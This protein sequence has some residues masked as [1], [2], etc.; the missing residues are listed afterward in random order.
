MTTLFCTPAQ[1]FRTLAMTAVLALTAFAMLVWGILALATAHDELVS[2]LLVIA[3]GGLLFCL[4]TAVF[5]LTRKVA[6]P[7]LAGLAVTGLMLHSL[8]ANGSYGSAVMMAWVALLPGVALLGA[9]A[10]ATCIES[11]PWARR[12]DQPTTLR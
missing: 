5:G 9:T 11:G 6:I 4:A 1:T 7:T 12:A 8:I 10:V 2:V 3:T